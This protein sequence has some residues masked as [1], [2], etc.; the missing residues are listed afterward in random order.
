MS[1]IHEHSPNSQEFIS[2]SFIKTPRCLPQISSDHGEDGFHVLECVWRHLEMMFQYRFFVL[3]TF[4]LDWRTGS[5]CKGSLPIF[6]VLGKGFHRNLFPFVAGLSESSESSSSWCDGFPCCFSIDPP[7]YASFSR[8]WEV[9]AASNEFGSIL[10]LLSGFTEAIGIPG[11]LD[12]I[13]LDAVEELVVLEEDR[14]IAA[15]RDLDTTLSS[16]CSCIPFAIVEQVTNLKFLVQQVELKCLIL[17]NEEDCS[18][19]HVWNFLWSVC[20]RVG[21]LVSMYLI[22]I[23]GSKLIR[24]NNQSRATLWVRETCLSV[25]LRPLTIILITFSLSSKTYNIA[26]GSECVVFGGMWSIWFSRWRSWSL[27]K[28]LILFF[29]DRLGS[30]PILPRHSTESEKT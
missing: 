13:G 7:R 10:I 16:F 11:L 1:G 5:V 25:G 9:D 30:S 12:A 14:F 24:S 6:T 19:H 8:T 26:L 18:T 22:W 17:K 28:H 2:K 27:K 29:Q 23:L 21:F 20:Q 15:S 3:L 4:L